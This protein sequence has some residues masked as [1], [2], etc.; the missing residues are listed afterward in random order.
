MPVVRIEKGTINVAR[1][2]IAEA[3]GGEASAQL[4]HGLAADRR[5]V[6]GQ[7]VEGDEEQGRR[8]AGDLGGDFGQAPD[9]LARV[10]GDMAP[11]V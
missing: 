2:A 8:N 7:D 3:L 11:E 10:S 4:R 9:E 1:S 5:I 6:V